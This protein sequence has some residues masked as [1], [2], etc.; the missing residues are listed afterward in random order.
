MASNVHRGFSS[1]KRGRDNSFIVNVP[2]YGDCW[3][4]VL[5]APLVGFVIDGW[6]ELGIL[7]HVRETL[8]DYVLEDPEKFVGIFDKGR[9]GLMKWAE[10][11]KCMG[12]YGGDTEFSVFT[13]ITG[14]SVHVL[15][16]EQK[17][18]QPLTH[19]LPRRD[20]STILEETFFGV[21]VVLEY[22]YSHYKAVIPKSLPKEIS[23]DKVDSPPVVE[24]I[25]V[26]SDAVMWSSDDDPIIKHIPPAKRKFVNFPKRESQKT[27]K[28]N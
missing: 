9:V 17:S 21:S 25:V 5:L 14:I 2:G 28:R 7:K 8:S 13:K 19:F 11:V 12:K 15:N 6:D 20:D 18:F 24:T 26:G 10:E 1:L 23:I 4:I 3:L 27:R 22:G 16:C